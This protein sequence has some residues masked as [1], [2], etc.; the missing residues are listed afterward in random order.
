MKS[1]DIFANKLDELKDVNLF[2]PAEL[3]SPLGCTRDKSYCRY[4]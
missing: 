3:L 4:V 1:S 2:S